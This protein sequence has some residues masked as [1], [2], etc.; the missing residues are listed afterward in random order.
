MNLQISTRILFAHFFLMFHFSS[1]KPVFIQE[2]VAHHR[3]RFCI[4]GWRFILC[5]LQI[6]RDL[7]R[8]IIGV[9]NMC[10]IILIDTCIGGFEANCKLN[11]LRLKISI[12]AISDNIA[13]LIN[14]TRINFLW[15]VTFNTQIFT[16]V[17]SN[18]Y[19]RHWFV[20]FFKIPYFIYLK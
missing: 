1:T 14:I 18:I 4:T 19:Y 8:C 7:M 3:F 20:H 5:C 11:E 2:F 9:W 17:K 12:H 13:S 10:A 6:L 16:F 15:N